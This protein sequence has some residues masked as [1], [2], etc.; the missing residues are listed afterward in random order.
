MLKMVDIKE[1]TVFIFET[2]VIY[3]KIEEWQGEIGQERERV[4]KL[5]EKYG[6]VLDNPNSTNSSHNSK[7]KKA[8]FNLHGGS[9][10]GQFNSLSL[11]KKKERSFNNPISDFKSRIGKSKESSGLLPR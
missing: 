10:A 7:H 2:A 6:V 1:L 11:V 4:R 9:T 5:A 3:A 8:G